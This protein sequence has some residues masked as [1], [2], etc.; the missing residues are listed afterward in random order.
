MKERHIKMKERYN[1]TQKRGREKI[2]EKNKIIAK[3][4][5]YIVITSKE[6]KIN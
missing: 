5:D 6:K 4:K 1:K 2:R 3:L